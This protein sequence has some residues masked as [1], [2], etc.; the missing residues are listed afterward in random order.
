MHTTF[1][2][3][4][5]LH[6]LL[7]PLNPTWNS[8][9]TK[10]YTPCS[11][12]ASASTSPLCRAQSG[13]CWSVEHQ[14]RGMSVSTPPHTCC[15]TRL[16]RTLSWFGSPAQCSLQKVNL[17]AFSSQG[18]RASSCW[19]VKHLTFGCHAV[20]STSDFAQGMWKSE[21]T[22]HRCQP[23]SDGYRTGEWS[24]LAVPRCKYLLC[25]LSSADGQVPA[26]TC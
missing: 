15:Q 16:N 5:E 10:R 9:G 25:D 14:G 23:L 20:V 4:S 2:S 19:E 17:S 8:R 21:C 11:S 6:T 22:C 26:F 24:Q 3:C 7:P 1:I 13:R 12:V 18:F